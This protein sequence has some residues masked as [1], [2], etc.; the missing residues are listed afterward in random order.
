MD[1]DENG[2]VAVTLE[3]A[4]TDAGA[5]AGFGDVAEVADEVPE[6]EQELLDAEEAERGHEEVGEA[7]EPGLD[8]EPETE[9]APAAA[10]EEQPEDE[11]AEEPE[12]GEPEDEEEEAPAP[13]RATVRLPGTDGEPIEVEFEADPETIEG[14]QRLQETAERVPALVDAAEAATE[15]LEAVD[16]EQAIVDG[17]R[18]R[19]E[20]EPVLFLS[21]QIPAEQRAA[22]VLDLAA[23]DDT[24]YSALIDTLNEWADNP[25]SRELHATR[26]RAAF[27]E[28]A[29]DIDQE[30]GQLR[31]LRQKARVVRSA[32]KRAVPNDPALREAIRQDVIHH[33]E[34]E[35]L[36]SIGPEDIA[37]IPQIAR[38][39]RLH[40]I[41]PSAFGA[42]TTSTGPGGTLR[43]A[44]Q[45]GSDA[46]LA[47]EAEAS[48]ATGE[49]LRRRR[50]ARRAVASSTPA[51]AG[52]PAAHARPKKGATLD[53]AFEFAERNLASGQG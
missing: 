7:E 40:K 15:R 47:E 26:R 25:N 39:L 16:E 11:S 46:A 34:K 14:L 51:G 9:D 23:A 53:E 38:R 12:A 24:V 8:E 3:Q 28:Q 49:Q 52:A 33:V 44:R 20:A 37:A 41:D 50:E 13:E 48:R 45:V 1:P 30:V 18:L 10:G 5:L 35:G 42:T 31:D 36:S 29:R 4:L 22:V 43:A 21:S 19:L 27:A 2:T 32:I 17:I 6:G